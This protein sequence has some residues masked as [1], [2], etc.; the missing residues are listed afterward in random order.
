MVS[1]KS[2][3][4]SQDGYDE[5]ETQVAWGLCLGGICNVRNGKT[6]EFV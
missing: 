3:G 1:L 5:S 2:R 4:G 6:S